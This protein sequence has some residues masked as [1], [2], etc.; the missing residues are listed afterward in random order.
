MEVVEVLEEMEVGDNLQ[1][2]AIN[3]EVVA[4]IATSTT[5]LSVVTATTLITLTLLYTA[6]W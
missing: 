3:R 6:P 4:T 1:S 2:S 5:D